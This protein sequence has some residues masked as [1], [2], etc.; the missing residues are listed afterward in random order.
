D[1]IRA[2]HILANELQRKINFA[3]G[4]GMRMRELL[5]LI[6]KDHDSYLRATRDRIVS[7]VAR[8]IREFQR[9]KSM[10]C[11]VPRNTARK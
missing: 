4:F 9:L 10:L 7:M 8:E 3:I 6:E 2:N 5:E 1:V 11:C